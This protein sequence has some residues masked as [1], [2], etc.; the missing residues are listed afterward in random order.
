MRIVSLRV[1]L[2]EA[3]G[4]RAYILRHRPTSTPMIVRKEDMA[5]LCEK[6]GDD[7]EEWMF[8]GFI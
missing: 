1:I 6:Y 5:A 8:F 4:E 3:P 2:S 7:R